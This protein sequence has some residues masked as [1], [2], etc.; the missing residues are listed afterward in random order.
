[1]AGMQD[2][3][4]KRQRLFRVAISRARAC[5]MSGDLERLP[6]LVLERFPLAEP[7]NIDNAPPEV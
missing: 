3:S 2:R 6:L 5:E 4:F 7:P 1:M